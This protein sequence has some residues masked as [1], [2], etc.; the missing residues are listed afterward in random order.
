MKE[1]KVILLLVCISLL[2]SGCSLFKEAE[3]KEVVIEGSEFIMA[4]AGVYDSADTAI[5]IK[6]NPEE[7][8]ISLQNIET[9]KSYTLNYDGT[10]EIKDKHEEAISMEQ[11]KLGDIVEVTFYKEPRRLNSIK[12]SPES[13]EY[14]SVE[15]FAFEENE[16]RMTI[17]NEEYDLYEHVSV[18]SGERLIEVIDLNVKDILVVKGIGQRVM[19]IDVVKGHG[20]LRLENEEQFID[21]WIEVGQ[22]LIQPITENMLLVVP[23]GEYQVLISHKGGGGTKEVTVLRDR[24]V[25]VDIGDFEVPEIKNGNILDRKTHT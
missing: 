11:L 14:L 5:I 2:L 10:T 19:S 8:A 25:V 22:A 1:K 6:K 21:G 13:W 4:V 12:V 16:E 3:E 15:K 24:E 23:E 20:Y 17:V 9:G 7:N 18:F